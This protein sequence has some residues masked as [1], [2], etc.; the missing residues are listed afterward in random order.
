MTRAPKN[1]D[2]LAP[3]LAA[4]AIEILARLIAFDTTSSATNL[5][6]IEYVENYL[7]GH[8]VVARR[9]NNADGSKANLLATIG[10]AE[11]R[12]LVLSGHTDVVPVEGQPWSR[13]PFTLVEDQGRLYGRGTADMKS[14]IALAL[15]AVPYLTPRKMT[16]PVHL[17]FSYDEEIGCLGAPDLINALVAE[18][19]RPAAA[20]VG[21]PTEMA[22]INSHKGIHLYEVVVTGREAHSSLV[23]EGVSANM[24]A[25]DILS[26]LGRIA[27]SERT[28][29]RNARF[30]PPWST[31]TVGT[32]HG[33][34]AAN[35]LAREC[36]FTFDLRTVPDR[37]ADAVLAPFWVAVETARTRLKAE[38]AETGVEVNPI[39]QVPPLRREEDG[40]AEQLAAMLC[41]EAAPAGAVSYGAEAGQFQIAGISTVICGP[42]SIVQAHRPD[43]YIEIAQIEAGA[44]FMS[45]LIAMT[46]AA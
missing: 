8:G 15:A 44:R 11:A 37:E 40:S 22:I 9:I 4:S 1:G 29:H 34:T 14:F 25:I 26:V 42:G 6:L 41:E 12:G 27:E 46:H 36:R 2:N 45:R 21:E 39:A 43:E 18:G 13:D 19:H 33:G 31:L 28:G 5:A 30:D 10:P 7:A 38:G 35:I 23:H 17:A 16:R 32:I 20:I 3:A 24:I